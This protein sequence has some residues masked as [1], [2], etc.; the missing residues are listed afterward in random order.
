MTERLR[1]WL[2][3]QT[4]VYLS[5]L[6][7]LTI[8]IAAVRQMQT[9]NKAGVQAKAV[10]F[11]KNLQKL[12]Q[13]KNVA[14]NMNNVRSATQLITR[15]LIHFADTEVTLLR[16]LQNIDTQIEELTEQLNDLQVETLR[17]LSRVRSASQ[18]GTWSTPVQTP[19]VGTYFSNQPV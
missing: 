5:T 2:L 14:T 4:A 16:R 6:E 18:N 3:D 15:A 1:T 12:A 9:I 7:E 8:E 17:A 11:S 19:R 13:K 10:T